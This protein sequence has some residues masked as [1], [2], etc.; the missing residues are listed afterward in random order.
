MRTLLVFAALCSTA[1]AAEW[2]KRFD[3]SGRPEV[4]V[5]ADDA[6][7][8][9][10]PGPGNSLEARLTTEGWSIGPEGIRVD[11]RQ[12]GNRIEIILKEPHR[13]WGFLS[14][15]WAKLELTVPRDL[16][17][18]IHT[19]DGSIHANTLAGQF[20]F[21]TGDGSVEAE[22][23]DGDLR[24]QTGD[25]S[26][27]VRGRFDQLEVQTG[28]GSVNVTIASGSKMAGPWRIHTGDGSVRVQV[29]ADLAAN[30]DAHTGDGGLHISVPLD[31][32]TRGENWVRGRLNTGGATLR[33]E[34]GDG[35]IHLDRL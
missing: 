14:H 12:N 10:R 34:T 28:D 11:A 33:V 15:R 9:L 2:S 21:V 13:D 17:A 26:I 18:D 25:G 3:L 4:R 22:G 31:N 23:V 30:V 27:R 7:V 24:A 35:S 20:K 6:S 29:P 19:G 32:S 5:D 16:R 1:F 8:T